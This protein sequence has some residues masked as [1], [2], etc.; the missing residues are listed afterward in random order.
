MRKMDD[1]GVRVTE[2]KTA[3][4]APVTAQTGTMAF[5]A[6]PV[7]Q[8]GGKVNEVVRCDSYADA[9]AAM[10]WS[11]DWEKYPLCEVIETHFKLYGVGP[12]LLVNVMDPKKYQGETVEE[13]V[14]LSFGQTRLPGDVLPETLVVKRGET[15]FE[16]G[17]D[18]DV[19]Y[20]DGE[21][22]LEVLADGGIPQEAESLEVSYAMVEF[23]PGAL[24]EEVVGGYSPRTGKSTGVELA[25][26][27]YFKTK[28]LPSAL[29]APGYSQDAR[30][31]AVLAA[32][33]KSLS[34]VFRSFA[35]CDLEAESYLEAVEKKGENGVFRR[36][37][38]RLCWPMVELEGKRYHLSTHLAAL[39]CR[40]AAD[41]GGIPSEPASNKSLQAD[42]VVLPDGREVSLELTPANHLRGQGITTAL[43]FVNGLTAWGEYCACAP[44]NTDPKDMS[45]NVALMMNYIA[46]TVILT[47]WN[48]IDQKMTPRL[49]EAIS[50]QVSY[51]INGLANQSHILGGRC[52]VKAE[53]NP[54]EDLCAGIVRVH[55]YLAVPG[56]AQKID[57][58]VE[59]DVSY[60]QSA[61]GLTA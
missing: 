54:V 10:G 60:I 45:C 39:T 49:A 40:L 61:F 26:V 19:F 17:K 46:N 3:V 2:K 7:H 20:E 11:D 27:A 41:N 1:F 8:T 35:I 28:V 34:V 21:C 31:A 33:A 57:F 44:E 9:V 15:T 32:K 16:A 59:Y 13:T 52:E 47:Y 42:A 29:I 4:N 18:Y 30:V 24:T 37:K 23:E 38:Q 56:P 53:E 58:I 50:D 14:A 22:V 51:W 25:D 12:L 43:N 55:I 6:A 5:G 48:Y 36:E